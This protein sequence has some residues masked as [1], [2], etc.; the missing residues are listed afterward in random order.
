MKHYTEL[1][2]FELAVKLRDCD[3]EQ[4]IIHDTYNVNTKRIEGWLPNENSIN[5]P[6]YAEVL[7]WLA[8]KEIYPQLDVAPC[9]SAREGRYTGIRAL[10]VDARKMYNADVY[11]KVEP[12]EYAPDYRD[13]CTALNDAIDKALE[14][15]AK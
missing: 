5:A 13:I 7:D 11:Y 1:V 15:L 2:P 14:I 9:D 10:V 4:S 6:T 8:D 12:Y 3:Y